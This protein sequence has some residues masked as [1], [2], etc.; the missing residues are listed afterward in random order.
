MTPVE[1]LARL[2]ALVLPPRVPLVI[3]HGVL[4]RHSKWR[5]AV[6]PKPPGVVHAHDLP[7]SGSGTVKC[8]AATPA[9][10]QPPTPKRA[11]PVPVPPRAERTS[12]PGGAAVPFS[13]QTFSSPP[14]AAAPAGPAV[15]PAACCA[16]AAVAGDVVITDFGISVR[17]LDRLLGGL[18][19]ATSPR[20]AWAKLIRRT[21]GLDAHR[22]AHCAGRLRLLAAITEKAT[23][24]KILEHLGLPADPTSPRS[25][26]RDP[27][28]PASWMDGAAKL[29]AA[30]RPP[31]VT[32][33]DAGT[34][35]TCG[36]EAR[37]RPR[38]NELNLGGAYSRVVTADPNGTRLPVK[39]TRFFWMAR[40]RRG[41]GVR[42]T[43]W[44]GQI[45]SSLREVGRAPYPPERWKEER[46]GLAARD[47]VAYN[48]G[49]DG[50]DAC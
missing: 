19:L 32:R 13:P 1:L 38:L 27:D 12:A 41:C 50:A 24:R 42:L 48:A 29:R 21:F 17:H 9:L 47:W 6:V 35:R 3:Y 11:A 2:A 8:D 26:T 20:I 10:M 46:T 23:A 5:T 37:R 4:A 7:A 45:S 14:L 30:T 43:G 22:C 25:Q 39:I 28:D 31:T 34:R 15:M 33:P 44:A 16:V 18:L 40:P 49:L 36:R